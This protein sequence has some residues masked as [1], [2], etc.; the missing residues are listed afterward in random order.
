[1]TVFVLLRVWKRNMVYEVFLN[2]AISGSDVI[3]STSSLIQAFIT[4]EIGPCEIVVPDT[5][6]FVS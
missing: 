4:L 3:I 1:M 6:V 2:S 5:K